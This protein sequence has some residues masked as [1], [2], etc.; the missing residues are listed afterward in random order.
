MEVHKNLLMDLIPHF[1]S[2]LLPSLTGPGGRRRGK[3]VRMTDRVAV[4]RKVETMITMYHP[5]SIRARRARVCA[6]WS[7]PGSLSGFAPRGAGNRLAPPRTRQGC[8]VSN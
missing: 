7:A 2:R 6:Y 5:H 1:A 8:M 4:H 3:R